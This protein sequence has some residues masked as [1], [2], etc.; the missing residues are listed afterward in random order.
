MHGSQHGQPL[1]PF[2]TQAMPYKAFLHGQS[3]AQVFDLY[4]T[5]HAVHQRAPPGQGRGYNIGPHGRAAADHHRQPL[6]ELLPSSMIPPQLPRI[7][8]NA[9][10]PQTHHLSQQ[11]PTEI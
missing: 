2:N 3:Q 1:G 5:S 10:N 9:P 6:Q 4:K 7:P 8:A 11:S